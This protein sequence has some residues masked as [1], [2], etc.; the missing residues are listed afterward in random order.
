MRGKSI[1]NIWIRIKW[2]IKWANPNCPIRL[3][4]YRD[5][6]FHVLTGTLKV[7]I[8]ELPIHGHILLLQSNLKLNEK[9]QKVW[10]GDRVEAPPSQSGS[11][12]TFGFHRRPA[13]KSGKAWCQC[14]FFSSARFF[15]VPV[16]A[17]S[18]FQ[19]QYL[20]TG[21]SN[22]PSGKWDWMGL[23]GASKADNFAESRLWL[24][25]LVLAKFWSHTSL[26]YTLLRAW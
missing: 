22:F 10:W 1:W 26:C 2:D 23:K 16:F 6:C 25:Y 21:S 15:P 9:R 4:T 3:F 19:H 12:H 5:S 14:P 18:G 17:H 20:E 11:L 8:M 7:D 24:R 13:R